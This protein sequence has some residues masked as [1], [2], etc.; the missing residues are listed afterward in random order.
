MDRFTQLAVDRRRRGGPRRRLGRRAPVRA[1]ADRLRDR[2]RDRR[3][4]LA[5]RAAGGP[6]RARAEGRLA[7]RRPAADGQRGRRR[8]RDAPRP[9]RADVRRDVGLRGR[10]A[11][12]RAGDADDRV[13]RGR[14]GRHRRRRGGAVADHGRRVRGDGRDLEAR[15]LAP[16]RRPPRR[17]RARRGRR[18][19]RARG[20]PGR[21]PIAAARR[22]GRLLGHGATSDAFHLTAPE[23]SGRDAARA[24]GLA[25]ADAGLEPGDV[26]YVNAHGTS[27]ELNDRVETEAIRAALGDAAAA[28]PVSSTK[29][30]IGHL[31]GAAGAVEAIATL[32]AL[33]RGIAP[34]TVGWAE[35]ER[36]P[37]PRLRPRTRARV[38][39]AGP[40]GVAISNSFGFGGHNAVLCIGA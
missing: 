20:R 34:P 30:A 14:R 35:R 13:G 39:P 40:G 32:G 18:D 6:R 3:D 5:R 26:D 29:S 12:D 28:I 8:G 36:G 37:R 38:S 10:R 7:A 19:P 22:S 15:D 11:R 31:L 1:G 27:T 4:R 33:R 9:P 17:L 25:L 24:I 21:W 2:D 23:P 16:V